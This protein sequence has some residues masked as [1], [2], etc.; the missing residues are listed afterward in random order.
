MGKN[1]NFPTEL[2]SLSDNHPIHGAIVRGKTRYLVGLDLKAES[3]L[4]IVQQ[5][6]KEPTIKKLGLN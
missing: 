1:N 6:L 5:F 2:L 4:P 3:E